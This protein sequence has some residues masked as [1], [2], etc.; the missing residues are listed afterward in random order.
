M[1]KINA[2]ND[3]DSAQTVTMTTKITIEH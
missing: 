1:F 2:I 3:D